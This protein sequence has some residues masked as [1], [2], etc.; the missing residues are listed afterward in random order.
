MK[1]DIDS[2]VLMHDGSALAVWFATGLKLQILH[3]FIRAIRLTRKSLGVEFDSS[4]SDV[5]AGSSGRAARI[6][7][8]NGSTAARIVQD[9]WRSCACIVVA[10]AK[11]LS[12]DLG[13]VTCC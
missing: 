9:Q 6:A 12:D 10:R 2:T 7:D 11:G 13:K 1:V 5:R 4:G 8:R 3:D